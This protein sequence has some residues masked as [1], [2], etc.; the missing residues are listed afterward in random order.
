MDWAIPNRPPLAYCLDVVRKK[1]GL[2]WVVLS[3]DAAVAQEARAC[4]PWFIQKGAS[5]EAVFSLLKKVIHQ[6]TS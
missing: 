5:P 2:K 6:E 1:P 4:S 3:V